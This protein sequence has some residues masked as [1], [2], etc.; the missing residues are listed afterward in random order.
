MWGRR[1]MRV[2]METVGPEGVGRVG[3]GDG[4]TAGGVGVRPKMVAERSS[5]VLD[6]APKMVTDS[7]PVL[8]WPLTMVGDG[9]GAAIVG[10]VTVGLGG[11]A[12]QPSPAGRATCWSRPQ[13][14][15][16]S[17]PPSEGA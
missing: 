7:S 6:V 14:L 10:G 12:Q 1:Q 9:S 4:V 11:D 15:A 3:G 13:G 2:G 8:N 5:P 16:Q 17:R